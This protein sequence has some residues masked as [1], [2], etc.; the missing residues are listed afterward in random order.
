VPRRKKPRRVTSTRG[1]SKA[2]N[3]KQF[4]HDAKRPAKRRR[5]PSRRHFTE[6]RAVKRIAGETGKTLAE[7]RK[8]NQE[9]SKASL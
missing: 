4:S 8:E 5:S 7:N 2:G 6:A 3:Q 9:K 1:E